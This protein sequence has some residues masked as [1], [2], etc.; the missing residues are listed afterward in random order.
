VQKHLQITN[1]L[2]DWARKTGFNFLPTKSNLIIFTIKRNVGQLQIT[3]DNTLIP[4]KKSVKILGLFFDC[5]HIWKTHIQ[6]LKTSTNQA[7]NI[8]K[9]LSH[10][11]WGGDSST[12]IKIHK[13]VIQSKIYYGSTIYKTAPQSILKPIGSIN[14]TGLSLAI[15]AYRSSPIY[16][17]YNIASEPI[18]EIKRN[19]LSLKYT[20]RSYISN[21]IPLSFENTELFDKLGK[22]GINLEEL[23]LREQLTTPPWTFT[24]DINTELSSL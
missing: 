14:N 12:L 10:T 8:L 24:Y 16:S 9:I 11:T 7:L 13:A 15:G 22:N 17:I 1:N 3:L 19:D 2:A 23:I 4:N 20:A 18:T 6:Y 21:N 5:R